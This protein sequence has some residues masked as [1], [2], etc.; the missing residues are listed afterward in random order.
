MV[1]C[2]FNGAIHFIIYKKKLTYINMDAKIIKALQN[3]GLI[4]NVGVNPDK[5]KTPEDLLKSGIITVGGARAKLAAIMEKFGVV[6]ETVE[7]IVE[8]TVEPPAEIIVDEVEEP[9]QIQET[10][11]SKKNNTVTE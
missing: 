7:P 6:E 9:V 10:K 8:E 5:Y 4:T 1:D 11:K 2:F 3:A